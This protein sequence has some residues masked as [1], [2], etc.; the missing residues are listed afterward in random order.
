MTYEGSNAVG[1]S[2][3]WAKPGVKVVC[4]E[5]ITDIN[6]LENIYKGDICII[7]KVIIG[8]RI[9][10]SSGKSIDDLP[11]EVGFTFEG[12]NNDKYAYM[13]SFFRPLVETA[14]PASLTSILTNPKKSVKR[15]QFD[16]QKTWEPV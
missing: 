15:D 9:E 11:Q 2:Y 10:K 3:S 5:G 6:I 4:I 13:A 8:N 16:K 12:M 1:S 7:K 14:L